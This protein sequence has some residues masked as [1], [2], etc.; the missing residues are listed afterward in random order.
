MEKR[1][2][3]MGY[4]VLGLVGT[5]AETVCAAEKLRPDLILMDI[6]LGQGMDGVEAAGQIRDRCQLPVVYLTA[7]SDDATVQRAMTTA[8]F[9]YLIKP[10]DDKELHAAIE[11]GLCRHKMEQR[12][13]ENQQWLGAMLAG[14]SNGV[15]ATDARGRVRFLNSVAE[16]LLGGTNQEALTQDLGAVFRVL[17]SD[18]GEQVASLA[19]EAM[20]QQAKRILADHSVLLTRQG[21][22][23]PIDSSAA[24]ILDL[25]GKVAGAMLVFRDATERRRMEGQNELQCRELEADNSRLQILATTDALTQLKSRR[26]FQE[27]LPQEIHQAR[28]E[29]KPLALLMLDMDHFKFFNDTLGHPAGDG[30]LGRVEGLLQENMRMGDFVARVGSEEFAIVLPATDNQE[31]KAIAERIRQAVAQRLWSDRPTTVSIGIASLIPKILASPTPQET[32]IAG[33][34]QALY[35]CKRYGRNRVQHHQDIEDAPL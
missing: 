11:I 9:G 19:R 22:H 24:P 3:R 2:E 17:H 13:H 12:L 32:F 27:K 33:A 18:S 35:V 31:A 29:G 21:Q 34:D 1:L 4:R 8:P 20:A 23:I 25:E 28:V 15:I 16:K 5:A 30:V 10:Y 6:W 26:A 7:H 14:I